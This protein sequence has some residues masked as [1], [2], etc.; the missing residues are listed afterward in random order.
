MKLELIGQIVLI[1]TLGTVGS[2]LFKYGIDKGA[3]FQFTIP[4]IMKFVLTPTIFFGLAFMFLGRMV[5]ALPLKTSG[6]GEV[7]VILT[8]VLVASAVIASAIVFKESFT[9]IQILGIILAL[10][11]LMLMEWR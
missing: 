11:S 1:A 2:L 6:L 9:P 7:T 4:S 5:W 8:P 10:I 3:E